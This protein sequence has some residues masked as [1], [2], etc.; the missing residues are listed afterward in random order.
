[1]WAFF[2][3][4]QVFVRTIPDF[5]RSRDSRADVESIQPGQEGPQERGEAVTLQNRLERHS[6]K[7]AELVTSK[8][9]RSK[10]FDPQ[11]V[12]VSC[13]LGELMPGTRGQ[14]G[15]VLLNHIS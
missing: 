12:F 13:C 11:F 9:A 10:R 4:L 7:Q 2:L 3:P 5:V 1:M 8:T 14:E 15:M 6:K